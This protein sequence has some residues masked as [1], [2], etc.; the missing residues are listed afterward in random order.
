VVSGI[1]GMPGW[2][3]PSGPVRD[4]CYIR[5]GRLLN[6]RDR[7]RADRAGSDRLNHAFEKSI[8]TKRLASNASIA[9]ASIG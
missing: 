5:R 2:G 7:G 3:A 4:C 9:V 6:G 1:N 8:G